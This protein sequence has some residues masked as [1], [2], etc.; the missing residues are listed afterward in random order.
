MDEPRNAVGFGQQISFLSDSLQ[1]FCD[2]QVNGMG[3]A[4][5]V[6]KPSVSHNLSDIGD[7]VFD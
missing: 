3:N 6:Q 2:F 7:I 1:G 4:S 5:D